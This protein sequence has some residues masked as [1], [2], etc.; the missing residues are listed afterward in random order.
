MI[1]DYFSADLGKLVDEKTLDLGPEDV[2]YIFLKVCLGL[3]YLHKN[4]IMHRV[5]SQMIVN[6][7]FNFFIFQ[8]WLIF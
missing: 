1:T 8:F 6:K 3:E 2:G 4:G 7:N 5:C